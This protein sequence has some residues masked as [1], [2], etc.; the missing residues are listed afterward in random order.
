MIRALIL[1][2]NNYQIKKNYFIYYNL[3]SRDQ[4]GIKHIREF[5]KSIGGWPAIQSNWSHE[6]NFQWEDVYA[7]LN[8]LNLYPPEFPF[9]LQIDVDLRNTSQ[10]I[11]I[12]IIKL[13][14]ILLYSKLI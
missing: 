1:V 13:I 3:E 9:Y 14:L 10:N 12:V 2:K 7:K 4:D 11:L 8:M 6:K 5:I